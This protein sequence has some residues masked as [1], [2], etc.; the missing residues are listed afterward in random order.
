MRRLLYASL[1]L[2]LLPLAALAQQALTIDQCREMAL[3]NNKD[4]QAAALNTQAA[5]YTQRSV[6]A[7]FFPKL[8]LQAVG[9]YDTGRG[10]QSLDF[11]S[12]MAPLGGLLAGMGMPVPQLPTSYDIDYKIGFAFSGGITLTQPLYMGGGLRT[13][14]SLSNTAVSLAREKERLTDAEVIER[15]DQAYANVVKA[16]ELLVVAKRRQQVLQEL[17]ANVSSAVKHGLRTENDRLKVQVKLSEVDLQIHRAENAIRLAS[18][19]LCHVTGQ[20]LGQGVAVSPEYPKVEDAMALQTTDI[21]ARP[22][23]A[24]LQYQSQMAEDVVRVAKSE[25]LPQLA[26]LAKYGYTRG[27]EVNDRMLLDGWNFAAGVTLRVPLYHFGEYTNRVKAA[28]AKQQQAELELQS[29]AEL[30]QLELTR[31]A[32]NLE[33]ARLECTLTDRSLEQAEANMRMSGKQFDNGLEPLS[34]YLEAQALWQKAYQQQVEARFQLF[35]ASDA[36][37]KAAG[38][39]MQ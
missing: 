10:T 32:N 25:M 12:V 6:H 30:M 26:L 9:L 38:L 31:A 2:V 15:T 8:S 16:T 24:M 13:A 29:K 28:Q 22:E 17:D 21:T 37:L 35:L 3:Q 34:D 36:Y 5:L 4:K 33:E 14:N 11:S 19:N 23:Y 39:L 18:M 20:P 1:A 7:L 27:L